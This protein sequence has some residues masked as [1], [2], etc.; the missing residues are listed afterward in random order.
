MAMARMHQH[1]A[2]ETGNPLV[3]MQDHAPM[4]SSTIRHR[5]ARQRPP[6][7]TYAD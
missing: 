1:P 2:S 7:L 5:P 3:D 6:V 4:P